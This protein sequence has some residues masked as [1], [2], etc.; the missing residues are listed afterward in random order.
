M[1]YATSP[2]PRACCRWPGWPRALRDA[3]ARDGRGTQIAPWTT[4]MRESIAQDAQD[5][6]TA[7]IWVAAIGSR[8]AG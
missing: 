8:L 5:E 7:A 3:L 4:A 2:A 1:P 6:A